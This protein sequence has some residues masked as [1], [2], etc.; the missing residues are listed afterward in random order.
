MAAHW[1]KMDKEF[2]HLIETVSELLPAAEQKLDD[3]ALICECFCV[4]A[5]DIRSVCSTKVDLD[6]LK[7]H[8]K[9]G[10]GCQTCTKNKDSWINK[11]F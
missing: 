6:L 9:M 7:S 8:F 4:N 11:I 5:G 10:Q 2:L 1:Y 3:D